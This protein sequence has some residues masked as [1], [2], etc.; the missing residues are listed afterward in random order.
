MTRKSAL[1]AQ[2]RDPVRG[3]PGIPGHQRQSF[4]HH[5]GDKHAIERIVVVPGQRTGGVRM[6]EGYGQWLESAHLN[7]AQQI[8]RRPELP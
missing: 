4:G 1:R 5:L 2:D 8:A 7:L 6:G 3:D